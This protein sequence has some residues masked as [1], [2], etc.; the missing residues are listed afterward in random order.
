MTS[1]TNDK[2]IKF[3]LEN[4]AD[5]SALDEMMEHAQSKV[6]DILKKLVHKCI[7][8]LDQELDNLD[9]IIDEDKDWYSSSLYDPDKEIGLFFGCGGDFDY[10]FFGDDPDGAPYLYLFVETEGVKKRER[11]AYIDK[12]FA[13]I[14]NQKIKAKFRKAGIVAQKKDYDEPYLLTYP[15]YQEINIET[16]KDKEKLTKDVKK[17]VLDFTNVVLKMY[18][19]K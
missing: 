17:A 19:E 4:Y 18:S 7:N 5:I 8:E 6:P 14:A 2:H 1:I 11:K 16:I 12:E 15:L 3:V 10:M 9:M 13:K